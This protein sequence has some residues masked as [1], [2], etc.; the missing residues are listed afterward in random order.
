VYT[1][2][3]TTRLRGLYASAHPRARRGRGR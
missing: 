2:V 3:S 1:H